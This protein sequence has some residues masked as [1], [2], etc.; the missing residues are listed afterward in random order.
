M[1]K[2]VYFDVLGNIVDK[3]NNL[4]HSTIK[5]KPIDVKSNSYTGYNVDSMLKILNLVQMIM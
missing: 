2:I 5:L 1:S 4:Y 3:Y